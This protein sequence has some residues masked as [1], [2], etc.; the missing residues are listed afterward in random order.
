MG[1]KL[2]IDEID[3]KLMQKLMSNADA[4]YAEIGEELFVSPGTIHVRLKKL[5]EMGII[6]NKKYEIDLKKIGFDIVAF[7]GVY[8]EKSS[9]YDQ[10][11]K[12]IQKLPQVIRL[13]Y[14]TGNYSMFIELSCRN[15][16]DLKDILHDKLQKINGIERTET[17]ISLEESFNR[18]PIIS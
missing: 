3:L 1:A 17:F 11:V 6:K 4:S 14:T 13:N 5:T 18:A 10:V 9:M 15:I 8:L 16:D 7:V 2:N 12:Q